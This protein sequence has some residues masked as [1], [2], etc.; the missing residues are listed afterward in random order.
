MDLTRRLKPMHLRLI[1]RIAETGKLQI[2]ADASAVSQPAASRLLAEIESQVGATLFIR[3]PKGMV[4]TAVGEAFVRHARAILVEFDSLVADVRGI[5]AG[6][7]GEVRVGSVSGP[8]VA[9]LVPALRRVKRQA[10]E[11]EATFEVGPSTELVRGLAEGR[12]DFV[13]ARLP[14]GHD[15]RELHVHPVR[16]EVVKL[17]ARAAHP[18]AGRPNI[19]LADLAHH[20]WVIQERGSPI[21]QAVEEAFH[22]G[23]VAIPTDITNTSSLL[24]VLAILARSDAVAPQSQEVAEMLVRGGHGAELAILDLDRPIAVAPCFVIHKRTRQMPRAAERVLEEVL[25]A[26]ADDG[27]ALAPA[28]RG[29]HV[30]PR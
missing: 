17:L 27:D 10:P 22:A 24:V 21:R 5:E 9:Y 3:H 8:A 25:A 6:E 12:F 26:V 13:I 29:P 15:S 18:L 2:A 30:G 14:A 28:A 1:V 16:G 11:V 7:A 19:G 20:E 4:P 23:A